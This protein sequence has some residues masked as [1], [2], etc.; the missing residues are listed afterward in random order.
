MKLD[1]LIY[2]LKFGE[3]DADTIAEA[4]DY[5]RDYKDVMLYIGKVKEWVDVA[6]RYNLD[7]SSMEAEHNAGN[8]Y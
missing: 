2:E 6:L 3:P 4:V 1:D 8:Q 7:H 5:L